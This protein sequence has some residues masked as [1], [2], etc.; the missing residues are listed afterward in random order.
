[1]G[2]GRK[3]SGRR[4]SR[5][6]IVVF[7]LRQLRVDAGD[8]DVVLLAFPARVEVRPEGAELVQ[9]PAFVVVTQEQLQEEPQQVEARRQLRPLDDLMPWVLDD[10]PVIAVRRAE[11]VGSGAGTASHG[12]KDAI[13]LYVYPDFIRFGWHRAS[14]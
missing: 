6:E 3:S 12:T 14:R 11:Q 5:H 7:R 9:L 8:L 13:S 2:L 4:E 1:M 10:E